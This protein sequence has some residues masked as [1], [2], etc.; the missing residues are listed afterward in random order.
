MISLSWLKRGKTI[1]GVH[2][3]SYV[4]NH[5]HGLLGLFLEIKAPHQLRGFRFHNFFK[6]T[7]DLYDHGVAW[8]C[9]A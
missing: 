9:V 3:N 5:L 6:Q 8:R 1:Y 7:T 2:D 4:W